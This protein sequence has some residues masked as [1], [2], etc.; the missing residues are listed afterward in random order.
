M[1]HRFDAMSDH[2]D[3]PHHIVSAEHGD[4]LRNLGG[5][6]RNGNRGS[7]QCDDNSIGHRQ[8]VRIS[9]R[10]DASI[11]HRQDDP[12]GHRQDDP[13]SPRQDESMSHRRDEPES[14][15][16]GAA[17]QD[18]AITHYDPGTMSHEGESGRANGAAGGGTASGTIVTK[19]KTAK[20]PP[21]FSA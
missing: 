3:S 18:G 9:H 2:D 16:G 1:S 10:H 6:R 13:I 15:G 5:S 12:I 4:A 17:A 8:T 14:H 19:V 20:E 7:D 11:S 21:R